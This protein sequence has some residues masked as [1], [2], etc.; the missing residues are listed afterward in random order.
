MANRFIELGGDARL[1]HK[2]VALSESADDV[3]FVVLHN[4]KKVIFKGRF[5]ITCS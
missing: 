4:E 2:V 1:N 3:T 5:L